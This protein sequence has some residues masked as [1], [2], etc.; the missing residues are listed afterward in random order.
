MRAREFIIEY[1]NRMFQYI[2]KLLPTWPDYV[3]K[4]LIY[5]NF[6]RGD[7][8]NWRWSFDMITDEIHDILKYIGLSAD[9][10]WEY[11]P[12][13]KFT[14]DM[15]EPITLDW[16]KERAGGARPK[17]INNIPDRDAEK[18]EIQ[19]KLVKQRGISKEP[20]ILVKTSKGYILREGWHRTIQ[21]G[22]AHV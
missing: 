21:I 6:A 12:N 13:M 8:Q 17:D 22:R 9:T 2:K 3:L 20:V 19:A 10:K 16:L 14:M 11:V 5:A 18:H 1:R 15:W 7:V 4:D